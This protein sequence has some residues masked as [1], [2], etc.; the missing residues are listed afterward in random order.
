[1]LARLQM[2]RFRNELTYAAK[3]HHGSFVP[4]DYVLFCTVF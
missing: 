4:S 1:M 2:V 3:F